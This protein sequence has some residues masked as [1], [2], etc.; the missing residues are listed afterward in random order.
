MNV[1]FDH[2]EKIADD[3]YSF[4]F[5]HPAKLRYV[6]GQ[7]IELTLDHSNIDNRGNRRWFTLSS[8]P[9]EELLCITTKVSAH[10]SSFK[11]AL[12]NL[13]LGDSVVISESMGD[14]ILPKDDSISLVFVAGGIG[15]T[16]F[17]SMIKWL[18]DTNS[19]R[20]IQL[21]YFAPDKAHV[22]F[23]S[24]LS[25]PFTTTEYITD[26]TKLTI[27]ELNKRIKDIKNSYIYVSGPE[28]MTESIVAELLEFGINKHHLVTDY[29][30]GYT[31]L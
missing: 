28:P 8:S 6:A 31:V 10:H 17:R 4:Y 16:P 26:G 7:F 20:E 11:Q 24:T 22:A 14:F 1:H 29:F 30:P 9:S 27:A 19:T 5:K 2:S 18:T 3:I 23:R 25:Q 13:K 15:V 21:L 12:M